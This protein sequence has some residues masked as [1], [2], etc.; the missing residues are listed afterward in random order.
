MNKLILILA[1]TIFIAGNVFT[2]CKSNTEKEAVAI[3]NVQEAE[4]N[5]DN[6]AD[7]INNDAIIQAKNA[8]WKTY[9]A[10]G[11]KRIAEN[12]TRIVALK[13]EMNKS[14]TTFDAN[15][16]KNIN[17]LEDRNETLKK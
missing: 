17:A 8:E 3:E 6:V 5:L 13:K 10:E 12:E 4:K 14:G 7:D 15:Y 2:S 1:I 16:K 11:Y 9:K